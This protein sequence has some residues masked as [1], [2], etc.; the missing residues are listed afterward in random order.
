MGRMK[1]V[2]TSANAQK[3][4]APA[5]SPFARDMQL[6]NRAVELA[7]QQIRDGTASSQI[8]TH[9]LKMDPEKE[10]LEHQKLEEEVKLLQAKT[11]AYENAEE[12][13]KMYDEAIKAILEYNGETRDD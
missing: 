11:K 4:Y 2:S 10:R 1:K 12:S 3:D 5:A 8:I 7:E 13:K 6:K 9:F